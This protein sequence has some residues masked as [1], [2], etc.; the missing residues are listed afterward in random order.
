MLGIGLCRVVDVVRKCAGAAACFGLVDGVSF[1]A[2]CVT[3][4]QFG[5]RVTKTG[6][7]DEQSKEKTRTGQRE[8]RMRVMTTNGNGTGGMVGK[9]KG[10]GHKARS[11][12]AQLTE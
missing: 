3:R 1:R 7:G 6:N 9:K 5:D 11:E 12:L 8:L 10:L 2:R 4:R